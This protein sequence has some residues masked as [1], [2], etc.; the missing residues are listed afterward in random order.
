MST[1]VVHPHE[2]QFWGPIAGYVPKNKKVSPDTEGH[3][4]I[5]FD[6]TDDGQSA[7]GKRKPTL[8]G[9]LIIPQGLTT[10]WDRILQEIARRIESAES[11]ENI[12]VF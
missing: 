12:R 8:H 6:L 11:L 5:D 4:R 1:I 7:G 10:G 2:T 3:E 9:S